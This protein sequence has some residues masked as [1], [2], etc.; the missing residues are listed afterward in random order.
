MHL[1]FFT[2]QNCKIDMQVYTFLTMH[3]LRVLEKGEKF[4]QLQTTVLVSISFQFEINRNLNLVMYDESKNY[5]LILT[6]DFL[7]PMHQVAGCYFKIFISYFQSS[8][9]TQ[10]HRKS[11]KKGFEFTLMVVGESGLGKSTLINSL[12]LTDLYPGM[13][14]VSY[15][16][17]FYC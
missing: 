8:Q 13:L 7:I 17:L 2:P 15:I 10:V 4:H 9:F 6:F 3:F 14:C 5:I 11:V 1:E 12:F 16:L